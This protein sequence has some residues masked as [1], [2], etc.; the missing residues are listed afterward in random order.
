M[1]Q[2]ELA[3]ANDVR[4]IVLDRRRSNERHARL[5]TRAVLRNELDPERPE[6]VELSGVRPASSERSEPATR[7][8]LARTMLAS[9]SIPLP[10]MPLKNTGELIIAAPY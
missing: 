9:G 2:P 4:D 10:P 1:R 8:P 7:A 6:I 3:R 5:Q